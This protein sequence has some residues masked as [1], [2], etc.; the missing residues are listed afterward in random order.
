MAGD[1]PEVTQLV[2]AETWPEPM[3]PSPGHFTFQSP[4]QLHTLMGP[5]ISA[6]SV[7]SF[8]QSFCSLADETDGLVC[9]SV[10]FW[11]GSFW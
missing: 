6:S 3:P 11:P 8:S 1:S 9:I 2:D 4:R 7:H 5:G 10:T